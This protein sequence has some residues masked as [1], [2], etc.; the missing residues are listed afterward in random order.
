MRRPSALPPLPDPKGKS[1]KKH[2]TVDLTFDLPSRPDEPYIVGEQVVVVRRFTRTVPIKGN[3]GFRC[4]FQKGEEG[5]VTCVDKQSVEK[6]EVVLRMQKLIKKKVVAIDVD[7]YV[8]GIARP[9]TIR[10]ANQ[11]AEKRN[12]EKRSETAFPAPS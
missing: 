7:A 12:A 10:A 4:D 2:S 9:S 1:D 5:F 11:K 6:G 8:A 3:A